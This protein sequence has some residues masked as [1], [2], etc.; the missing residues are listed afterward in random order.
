M[1]KHAKIAAGTVAQSLREL[2]RAEAHSKN[3]GPAG[4]ISRSVQTSS[5][6]RHRRHAIEDLRE[7]ASKLP[8]GP[9]KDRASEQATWLSNGQTV[10]V[11]QLEANARAWDAFAESEDEPREHRPHYEARRRRL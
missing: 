5:L 8:P 6:D 3:A 1:T 9:E 7:L 11:P 4:S 2:A 10:S